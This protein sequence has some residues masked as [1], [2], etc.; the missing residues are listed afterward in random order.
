MNGKQ[1]IRAILRRQPHDRLGWDFHDPAYQDI[2]YVPGP[3]SPGCPA[4]EAR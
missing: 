3:P 1:R 4:S 2:C